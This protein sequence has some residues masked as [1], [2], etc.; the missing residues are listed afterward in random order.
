MWIGLAYSERRPDPKCVTCVDRFVTASV[1][2]DAFAML[3][4]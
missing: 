3:Q 4:R 2:A 1:E